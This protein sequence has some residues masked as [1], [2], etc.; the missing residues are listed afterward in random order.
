[1]GVP[2]KPCH[3]PYP[4]AKSRIFG[5]GLKLIF[6]DF[7]L[8]QRRKC[9]AVARGKPKKPQKFMA[10]GMAVIIDSLHKRGM[11]VGEQSPKFHGCC[12]WFIT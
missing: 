2:K 6:D 11:A 3:C 5:G 4:Y 1:M 12:N 7:Y 10:V 9:M 8:G